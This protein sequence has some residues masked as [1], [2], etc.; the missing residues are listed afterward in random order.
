MIPEL[1]RV[2]ARALTIL[3]PTNWDGQ[4]QLTIA[5]KKRGAYWSGHNVLFGEQTLEVL[6]LLNSDGEL[7]AYSA[8]PI[9]H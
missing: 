2:V 7:K 6:R 5:V 1:V 9:Q 3:G 8:V 4:G